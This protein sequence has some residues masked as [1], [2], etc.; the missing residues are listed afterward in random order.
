[1]AQSHALSGAVAYLALAPVLDVTDTRLVAVGV[2][3][4]TGAAMLPDL[5]QHGSTIG[6]T[7]GPITNV[8]AR[9]VGFVSGGHRNGT[10]S[11]VGIVALTLLA[12]AAAAVGGY[13]LAFVL[14]MLL[15]VAARAAGLV[16][17]AHRRITAVLHAVV[18]A[19]VVALVLRSGI[20]YGPIVPAAVLIGCA[21]HVAGDMLTT[22][23]CPLLWPFSQRCYSLGLMRTNTWPE[24]FIVMPS[25]VVGLVWL[26]AT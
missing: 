19:G 4:A 9:L 8:F 13:Y 26:L 14:W 6:R 22:G 21:A 24:H 23:G 10:H 18:M 15:G 1:M 12:T 5:D 3:L 7:Y 16:V 11:L 20:D 17:P 25:L 2:G